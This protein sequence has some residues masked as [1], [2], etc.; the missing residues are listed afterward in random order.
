MNGL[1]DRL[2]E[3]ENPMRIQL[4]GVA[5]SGMSGLALLLMGM[6]HRVGG[7]D[8]VTTRE[9]ERMQGEGLMFSSPHSVESVADA[10]L[11]VYSSAIRDDNAA[12][13]AARSLGIP[14]MRRAAF[15]KTARERRE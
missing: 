7:S 6:G 3:Q 8:R 11:V 12:L 9:T 14:T 15:M 13:A 5:G 2:T 4:I 10:D 1:S